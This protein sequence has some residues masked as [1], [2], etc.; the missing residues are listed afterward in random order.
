MKNKCEYCGLEFEDW[1]IENEEEYGLNWE[2]CPRCKS[3]DLRKIMECS[4]CGEETETYGGVCKNCID[5]YK[6]NFAVCYG[7]SRGETTTYKLSTIFSVLFTDEEIDSILYNHIKQTKPNLDCSSWID[8]DLDWFGEKLKKE[9][10][11]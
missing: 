5:K 2:V 9:V 8:A 6:D 7:T 4:I 11:G 1:E 10:L 3:G